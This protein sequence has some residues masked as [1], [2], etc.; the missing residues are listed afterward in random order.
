MVLIVFQSSWE[1]LL[2]LIAD[3]ILRVPY[4]LSAQCL[5]A[6]TGSE[7]LL[8]GQNEQWS[9]QFAAEDYTGG[10][11]TGQ[12]RYIGNDLQNTQHNTLDAWGNARSLFTCSRPCTIVSKAPSLGS[13]WGTW[14]RGCANGFV[15]RV[16]S[17]SCCVSAFVWAGASPNW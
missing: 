9:Q 4:D 1:H 7:I 13:G 5:C 11:G 15:G 14:G 10:S 16:S 8:N 3:G 6:K 2:G 12:S 17:G